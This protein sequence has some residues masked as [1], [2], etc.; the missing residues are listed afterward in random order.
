MYDFFVNCGLQCAL[1]IQHYFKVVAAQYSLYF[2][3]SVTSALLIDVCIWMMVVVW[4]I[5]SLIG[6]GYTAYT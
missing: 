6:R 4:I 5:G 1:F 3:V 2:F